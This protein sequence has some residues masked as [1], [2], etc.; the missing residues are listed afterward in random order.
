MPIQHAIH[1]VRAYS[2]DQQLRSYLSSLSEPAEVRQ[3]LSEIGMT[4]H[5]EEFEDAY[6]M[7]V[8]Q[9]ASEEEH[10]TLFQI[11]LSYTALITK[12]T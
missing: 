6:N 1:F 2:T 5:D 4:F 11:K 8:V 10:H 7:L 12:N 3:F 9:C